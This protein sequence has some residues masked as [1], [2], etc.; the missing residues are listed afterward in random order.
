MNTTL[1]ALLA[2][3]ARRFERRPALVIRPS[4][5]THTWTYRDLASVV[6][7][8][9][10]VLADAGVAPGDRVILWAANRPEWG[11]A[12]LA[13]AHAGAVAKLPREQAGPRG[14]A[15]RGRVPVRVPQALGGE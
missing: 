7:R 5:R 1:P 2:E 8:A 4:F 12:F 9:A 10:R 3:S 15:H 14:R 6:P 11:I 13:V